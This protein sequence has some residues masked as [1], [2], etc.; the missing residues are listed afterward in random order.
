MVNNW[1]INILCQ[2]TALNQEP[3]HLDVVARSTGESKVDA[4][5]SS[6]DK[7]K[8]TGFGSQG[9][10]KEESNVEPLSN[11]LIEFLKTSRIKVTD[12][13]TA[14][15]GA[16]GLEEVADFDDLDEEMTVSLESAMKPLEVKRLATTPAHS[17]V[18]KI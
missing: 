18:G 12:K 8:S 13:L 1:K 9:E 14:A 16:L 7:K 10:T 15:F 11:D 6:S 4:T 3:R 2:I 17:L 5:E